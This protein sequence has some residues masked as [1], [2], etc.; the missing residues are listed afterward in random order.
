ML[1]FDSSARENIIENYI[2]FISCLNVQNIVIIFILVWFI[3]FSNLI[4]YKTIFLFI[5]FNF[6]IV[7]KAV[8][9]KIVR[10]I[11]WNIYDRRRLFFICQKWRTNDFKQISRL[12]FMHNII[13]SIE[14]NL[15]ICIMRLVVK[16]TCISR[17]I[18]FNF[19][20][21]LYWSNLDLLCFLKKI[22]IIYII[23]G[24]VFHTYQYVL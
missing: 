4:V 7:R 14:S 12:W 24:L 23:I 13:L 15:N 16:Y 18:L 17:Y 10:E 22:K 21:I 3:I 9:Q 1:H 11:P 2:Y 6:F 19:I 20:I 8:K 5:Y